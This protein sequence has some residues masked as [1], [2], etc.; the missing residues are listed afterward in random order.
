[1]RIFELKINWE[2]RNFYKKISWIKEY[3]KVMMDFTK[4]DLDK[5]NIL[6]DSSNIFFKEKYISKNWTELLVEVEI[7][8]LVE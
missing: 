1:M 2:R 6:L 3:L 8:N 4:K 7:H 5:L